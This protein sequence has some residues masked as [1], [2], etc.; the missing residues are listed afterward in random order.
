MSGAF[1]LLRTPR[2]LLRELVPGDAPALLAIESDAQ[3]MRWCGDNPMRDI[4][5]ARRQIEVFAAWRKLTFA[6]TKWAIERVSDAALIGTC[7]LSNWRPVCRSCTLSYGL[8]RAAW[9][10]GCMREA[11]YAVLPWGFEQ[12]ALNRVEAQIHPRNA[13]SRKL[14]R[15]LGFVEEG[16]LREAGFWGGRHRDMLQCALL[17]RDHASGCRPASAKCCA[18]GLV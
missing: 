6:A 16:L 7:A 13:A 1:P 9:G 11:L 14:A 17:R 10:R 3:A 5:Q 15:G 12:M 8:A 4:E 2:L 18:L